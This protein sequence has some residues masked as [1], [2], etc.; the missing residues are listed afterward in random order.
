ML[1]SKGLAAGAATILAVD[2]PGKVQPLI[3]D[4][5]AVELHALAGRNA[6]NWCGEGIR[7]PGWSGSADITRM[8]LPSAS[9]V[10]NVGKGSGISQRRCNK[11]SE[12]R[13]LHLVVERL[14]IRSTV[15]AV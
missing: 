7:L 5:D 15:S 13:H 3:V 2:T 6:G 11:R 10:G 12:P 1:A 9:S 14:G 4:V 8:C